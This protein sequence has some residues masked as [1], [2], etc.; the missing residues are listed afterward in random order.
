MT[1][2]E[3]VNRLREIANRDRPTHRQTRRDLNA[4]ADE[5]DP[6]RPEPGTVVWWKTGG[7]WYLGYTLQDGVVPLG[8]DNDEEFDDY[9]IGWDKVTWK[10]ARILADED[11][12]IMALSKVRKMLRRHLEYEGSAKSAVGDLINE[13]YEDFYKIAGAVLEAT[14]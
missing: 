9:Y 2:A 12:A 13:I 4:I 6:Q 8:N 7:K 1:N 5:L 3:I 10:P 11:D 14:E